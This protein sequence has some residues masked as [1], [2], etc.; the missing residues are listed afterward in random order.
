MLKRTLTLVCLLILLAPAIKAEENECKSFYQGQTFTVNQLKII[1]ESPEKKAEAEIN[2]CGTTL[3][4]LNLSGWD[5]SH[6]NL[7]GSDLGETI[8]QN[9]NFSQ[10]N[11][12]KTYFASAD[13]TQANLQKAQLENARLENAKL[14]NADLR[15]ANLSHANLANADLRGANLTFAI[16]KGANLSGAMLNQAILVWTDLSEVDLSEAILTDANLE[17]ANLT[18]AQLIKTAVSGANFAE[19]DLHQAIFQPVLKQL[20]DLATFTSVKNFQS[21]QFTDFNQ[22]KAA[23]TELRIAYR[24]L[25]I[26]SMERVITATIKFQEMRLEW[27]KGGWLTIDSAFN[28][29]FFYLTC[30]YGA[31][32]GKP[33]RLFL[34]GIFLFAIPY[35]YALSHPTKQAGIVA[36]WNKKRFYQWDKIHALAKKSEPICKLLSAQCLDK[37]GNRLFYQ[38]HLLRLSLFFSLLSAFSIGWKDINVS[39]WISHMQAREF[40]LKGK[41]WVHALAG[42]QS[43]FSAYMIVLWVFTYF[44]RPFEW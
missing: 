3:H 17:N 12:T 24:E 31:D 8:L 36:I 13:L 42:I 21:I 10:A 11:L 38:F 6:I 32:P 40:T 29:V 43:L 20:P 44:A 34:L 7:L 5:L 26:R 28:Y 23:L 35:R 30:N 25:G 33:L 15:Q 39:N 16:L 14:T 4:G 18:G 2:L 9:T 19:A 27:Q 37:K 22:W 41:G 1:L